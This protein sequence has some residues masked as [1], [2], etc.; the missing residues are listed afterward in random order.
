MKAS[1]VCRREAIFRLLQEH[2]R[3]VKYVNRS[4][5]E[6]LNIGYISSEIVHT[7]CQFII[8]QI[9]LM[10]HITNESNRLTSV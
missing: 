10:N 9:S 1:T 7:I 8:W 6:Q 4:M 3:F 2:W 5:E